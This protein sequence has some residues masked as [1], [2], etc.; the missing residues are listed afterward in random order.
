MD[1]YIIIP[2]RKK[3]VDTG[4]L[5]KVFSDVEK[6]EPVG[7]PSDTKV[8]QKESLNKGGKKVA[9]DTLD[10]KPVS[11]KNLAMDRPLNVAVMLPF[12]AGTDTTFDY[13]NEVPVRSH[14]VLDF[15]NGVLLAADTMAKQGMNL[16][17][18]VYDTQNSLFTLREKISEVKRADYDMLIGPLFQKVTMLELRK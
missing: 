5:D 13:D 2:K 10:K 14:Y 11:P 18:K 12:M 9:A 7:K 15:Y 3:E 16:S 8:S 6:S 1:K 17:M 4:W